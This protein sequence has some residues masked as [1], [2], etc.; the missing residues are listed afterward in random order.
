MSL[1]VHVLFV[2]D[3]T[4]TTRV[5]HRPDA[6]HRC[7]DQMPWPGWQTDTTSLPYFQLQPLGTARTVFKCE[8]PQPCNLSSRRPLLSLQHLRRA[9]H[10]DAIITFRFVLAGASGLAIQPDCHVG[11]GCHHR[12]SEVGPT[13]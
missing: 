2:F 10:G 1:T 5:I 12:S 8:R 4:A 9:S 3:L 6:K 7:V 13:G 11:S